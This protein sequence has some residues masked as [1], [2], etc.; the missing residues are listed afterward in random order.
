MTESDYTPIP[1]ADE[2]Y[3][4]ALPKYIA[5]IDNGV[6]LTRRIAGQPT[7]SRQYWAS[8]LFVRLCSAGISILHLC[9]GSPANPAGKYW[10]FSSLAPLVR[11]LVQ[12]CLIHFYLG[13]EPV[14]EDEAQARLLVMQL[15]DCTERLRLFKNGGASNEKI[16]GIEAGAN[17]IRTQLS[18]NKYFARLPARVRKSLLKGKTASILTPGQILDRMGILDQAGRACFSFIS[19]HADLST[20]AYYKTGESNRGRGDENDIDKYY[21]A[22]AVDLAC[23]FVL[24]ANADMKVLFQEAIAVK[25]QKVAVEAG[26][27]RFRNAF[28]FVKQGQ[29][30]LLEEF[31]VGDRPESPMLCSECFHDVGLRLSA[32]RI[33]QRDM[34]KCPNCGSQ[35][36]TKLSSRPVALLAREFFVSGTIER[37]RYGGSPAVQFNRYQPTSIDVMPWLRSDLELISRTLGVG[38]FHYGPPLWTLGEV[39]PLKA[40]QEKSLQADI[41]SRIL[42]EYPERTLDSDEW[43][44]RLRKAPARPGDFDQYDPPPAEK[45]GQGRFDTSEFPILYGSQD[46]E[47]CIHECRVAA[48]DEMYIATLVPQRRLKLLNLAEPL[49]EEHVTDFESLDMALHM[50]FL[51]GRDSYEISREIAS[52]AQKRGFD[53]LVYPSYFTSLRT[54]E[55]PFETA[56]GASNRRFLDMHELRK[57]TISN[58]ALFGRPIANQL[59][60]VQCINKVILNKV[61]YTLH[62]GPLIPRD[63]GSN[64]YDPTDPSAVRK[65][66]MDRF[67]AKRNEG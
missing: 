3:W 50:L 53:G 37:G 25:S 64:Y 60:K 57:N 2:H 30:A 31:T 54:G 12:T 43:F 27:E 32:E 41:I 49:R 24:R 40:L 4:T 47:V 1:S 44:Y 21:I 38:F 11:G 19:S 35:L 9:P 36:G 17:D 58:L 45:L 42:S 51:A 7:Q 67:L 56:Y 20:L 61:E 5:A 15:Q 13:T 63:T 65:K 55:I 26:S 16:L 8:V 6:A 62:F 46:L 18:L 59:V 66:H 52:S 33:G 22:T 48:E 39:E 10:D 34:S 28:E 14:G 23:H 29:G